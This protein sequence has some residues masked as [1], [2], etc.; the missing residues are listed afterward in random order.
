M[1]MEVLTA[2]DGSFAFVFS[3]DE[4]ESSLLVTTQQCSEVKMKQHRDKHHRLPS[5]R[6]GKSNKENISIVPIAK[7]RAY[8]QLFRNMIAKEVAAEL[9]HTWI[10][11]AF[12]MVAIPRQ[13]ARTIKKK[14]KVY[15]LIEVEV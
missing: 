4:K 3:K 10:D 15:I 11:P 9:T 6:G 14:G 2:D 1:K 8:H 5:S 12:Y 7:H 13:K